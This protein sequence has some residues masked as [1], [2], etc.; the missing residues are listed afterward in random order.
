[1]RLELS[2]G[3]KRSTLLLNGERDLARNSTTVLT[4]ESCFLEQKVKRSDLTAF[5]YNSLI[6][7]SMRATGNV[8]F[9]PVWVKKNLATVTNPDKSAATV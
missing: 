3:E 9:V 4:M 7:F 5:N 1:M 8:A 6:H 2:A